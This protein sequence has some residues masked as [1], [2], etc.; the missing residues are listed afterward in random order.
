MKALT[1]PY[2]GILIVFAA[3]CERTASAPAAAT[4]NVP[5]A[6]R[7]G[8]VVRFDPAS[9]Q[10]ERLRVA[11]VNE[12]VVPAD[13]FEV[14]GTIEPVPAR[15]ARLALPVPGRVR[16]VLVTLGDR[17]REGQVL[18]SIDTPDVS[19]LQSMLR[20][21][22]ADVRQRQAALAKAEADLSRARDLLANRAIAQ[23]D[24]LAAEQE[25]AFTEAA[26]EQAR[27]TEDDV[28]RRLR[29]FGVAEDQPGA[30]AT[31]RSPISG[32][33]IEIAA[34]PGEYR[35]DTAA[36]VIAV[37]DL[38]R[39]WVAASVPE[40][41]LGRVQ[42][43]EAVVVSVAAY[44]DEVFDGRITRIAGTL[45]P[46][47]R[48]VRVIAELDNRNRRLK[49]GMFARVRYTGP[50]RAAVDVP[51]GAIIRDEGRTSVFVER[52]RGQFERRNVTLGQRRGNTVVV[53]TGLTAGERI[54][55]DGTMLLMAQ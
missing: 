40:S 43:G 31:L 38:A 8:D 42:T 4:D 24:V 16:T 9:P 2:L 26:L 52:A 6:T 5:G 51:V 55:V 30:V 19:E 48:S 28:T 39:V 44:P 34:S 29:L 3:A 7:S 25:L 10:L 21:A 46:E 53:T 17:V 49:P 54:V 18:L 1:V 47:T 12:A 11:L 15:V 13:E 27:A 45:D 37:A 32:E 14:P 36:P 41:L 50:P 23:K 33:V 20:Q 22:R 35:N